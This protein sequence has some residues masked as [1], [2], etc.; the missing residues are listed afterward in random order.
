MYVGS[1]VMI[2]DFVRVLY[3][4][5]KMLCYYYDVGFLE[6]SEVDFYNGYCYYL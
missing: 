4:S 3:L 5:V 2:G 6:F 1:S